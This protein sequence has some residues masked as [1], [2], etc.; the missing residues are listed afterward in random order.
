MM[1][2]KILANAGWEYMAKTLK[3]SASSNLARSNKIY[4]AEL[5]PRFVAKT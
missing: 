3:G 4:G 2:N 1:M 5:S